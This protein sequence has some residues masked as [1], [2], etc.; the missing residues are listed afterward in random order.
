MGHD[1]CNDYVSSMEGILLGYGRKTGI[2]GYGPSPGYVL[3][4]RN[5]MK[6]EAWRACY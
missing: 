2:G 5:D 6:S 3:E 1:H 4:M